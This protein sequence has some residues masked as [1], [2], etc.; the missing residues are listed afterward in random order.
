MSSTS[1]FAAIPESDEPYWLTE[2]EKENPSRVL[3]EFF[4]NNSLYEIRR[5][6][7]QVLEVCATTENKPFKE[8]EDRA[9]LFILHRGL[10]KLAEACKLMADKIAISEEYDHF[11]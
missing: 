5:H 3:L 7:S 4:C 9:R 10:E 1:Y 11:D 2:A 6:L 8:P